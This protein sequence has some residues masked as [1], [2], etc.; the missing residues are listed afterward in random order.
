MMGT[1]IGSA[2]RR[3]WL[4]GV[5]LVL[6]AGG[7][8]G[9]ATAQ[10]G[11]DR[12]DL[13]APS[14]DA[15]RRG[16]ITLVTGDE[17]TV[18]RAPR[19]RFTVD[20]EAAPRPS[21]T[22]VTFSARQEPDGDLFVIPSD[23]ELLVA[24]GVLEQDLFNVG[25][26]VEAG[27]GDADTGGLP[28]IVEYRARL[29]ATQ[30]AQRAGELS[31]SAVTRTLESIDAVAVKT[32][33]AN[34]PGLWRD[35]V[36]GEP[37]TPRSLQRQQGA[38]AQPDALTAGATRVWLDRT[39]TAALDQ[40]VPQIGAPAVWAA[41]YDGTGTRVAVLDTGVD[42]SHPDVAGRIVA[43]ESF[44]AGQAVA[45]GHGHGTHVAATAAGTGAGSG[46]LRRGVAPGADLVIGKVLA[47]SG[48]GPASAVIDGMEWAALE[49]D[50]DVVSMSLSACCTDG[51]D[52]MSQAVNSL[53]AASG[54]LFVVA[55]GNNGPAVAG[56]G[57]PGVADAALTVG[58]VDKQD[59]LAAFSSR[60]PR[61]GDG[62]IKPDITGP[63]VAIAAARAAGTSIG[64]P[65]DALYTRVNGTSM[66][67]PHVAGA[68]ALLRQANPS[69][70]SERIKSALT[71][72]ARPGSNSVYQQGAGRVDA[73][74]AFQQ[75][76]YASPATV[77]MAS[78][79]AG[80]LTEPVS[81]TLTFTNDREAAVRL[82]LTL[83]V[84]NA[85]NQPVADHGL[86]LSADEITVAPGA[87]SDVV[88]RLD[89]QAAA[90]GP[91]G[92]VVEARGDG[93]AVTRTPVGYYQGP[94][95]HPLKVR[96]LDSTGAPATGIRLSALRIDDAGLGDDPLNAPLFEGV[97]DDAGEA[98]L[99]VPAGVYDVSGTVNERVTLTRPWRRT[100]V[101][102]TE[103]RI[104]GETTVTL[105]ARAGVPLRPETADATD[106]RAVRINMSR[107]TES[108]AIWQSLFNDESPRLNEDWYGVPSARARI[109]RV[110]FSQRW[111][112]YEPLIDLSAER[113]GPD[114]SLHPNYSPF[115]YDALELEGDHRYPMEF[116]HVSISLDGLPA[117]PFE[118]LFEVFLRVAQD[119]AGLE[120]AD[121]AVLVR[122]DPAHE[123][124]PDLPLFASFAA[125]QILVDAGAVAVLTYADAPGAIAVNDPEAREFGLSNAE[126]EK[127]RKLVAEDPDTELRI[128]A[129]KTSERIYQLHLRQQ[130]LP[131]KRPRVE[132]RDLVEIDASYHYDFRYD[133]RSCCDSNAEFHHSWGPIDV[134][135]VSSGVPN[136]Q[137]TEREERVGPADDD[138]LWKRS[139][140][141]YSPWVMDTYD[142]FP[143]SDEIDEDWFQSPMYFG[144]PRLERTEL[145]DDRT[146]FWCAYCRDGDFFWAG[147]RTL[148]DG[149][150]NN[151][152][153]E[154]VLVEHFEP[155]TSVRVFRN[156]EEIA[157]TARPW[158]GIGQISGFELSPQPAVYTVEQVD[159][160]TPGNDLKVMSP[161][162]T[163]SWSFR[164]AR[165]S[166][167][168][169]LKPSVYACPVS[170]TDRCAFQ[171]LIM[172]DYDLGL[173]M[174]NRAPADRTWRFTIEPYHV[175]PHSPRIKSMDVWFS[176][177]GGTTWRVADVSDRDDGFRVSVRHPELDR[178][179]GFVWLKVRA[180]D[181]AG[182][183][184]AQTTERAYGLR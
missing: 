82:A 177:D 163:T 153:G 5:L 33:K 105:D 53:S 60:G 46:G 118:A 180:R 152:Y 161:R 146:E 81:R 141:Q 114:L 128:V 179:D 142:V 64:N 28:L 119:L 121:K 115:P 87:T 134:L 17:V 173:D 10:R 18:T 21:G 126:G 147:L 58:A 138:V 70:D 66:A 111:Q 169:E 108:G 155:A 43:S 165:P 84:R 124:A 101:H 132:R 22:R 8:V 125:R 39:L 12:P 156:G 103:R 110:E 148:L 85:A 168:A 62:R 172:L 45:D 97:T 133:T 23:A 167:S 41:G 135:S 4:G 117:D 139:V 122:I 176:T 40:S 47:N 116:A 71:S 13:G 151:H 162:V 174:H 63:G 145:V 104:D 44:I 182:N 129:R 93:E 136:L 106:Q 36:G 69:W 112:T 27:Y 166:A 137:P 52:P 149:G 2:R 15:E 37:A 38:S 92:A 181:Q 100:L 1:V 144:V 96:I 86:S 143:R 59:A 90:S 25:W 31:G 123:T 16:T 32:T 79:A 42:A 127:L 120:A 6:A 171:P 55:A 88:V 65:V 29:S 158:R 157:A 56:I 34:A 113:R 19:G 78:F 98:E 11:A 140:N 150:S 89:P 178:T 107:V 183:S 54:A 35:L 51:S 61:L 57:T 20:I 102:A 109:G 91:I 67:T 184:I 95:A 14:T 80:E 73:A 131:T 99:V 170:T 94:R 3:A 26:L 48:S 154:R 130:S 30:Q 7:L 164:S 160:V 74:R 75:R 9:S 77:H 50:A 76:V 159:T 49:H 68:A 24:G 83:D 72:T 175:A